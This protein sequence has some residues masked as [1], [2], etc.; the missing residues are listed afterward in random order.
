[1]MQLIKSPDHLLLNLRHFL[2]H[3]KREGLSLRFWHENKCEDD[4]VL[5]D[6][7]RVMLNCEQIIGF[8]RTFWN[9]TYRSFYLLCQHIR[10]Q[11]FRSHL[12]SEAFIR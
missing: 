2:K 12:E 1:M 8:H 9:Q 10:V 5:H 6:L 4:F 7:K 11:A 3:L